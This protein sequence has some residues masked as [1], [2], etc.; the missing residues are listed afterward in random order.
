MLEPER[1]TVGLAFCHAC[2]HHQ[3]ATYD[4]KARCMAPG[5]TKYNMKWWG[6]EKVYV[7][8]PWKINANN[9]CTWFIAVKKGKR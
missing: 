9:G 4:L 7:Q 5:N 3:V 6:I 8:R 2:I 1:H